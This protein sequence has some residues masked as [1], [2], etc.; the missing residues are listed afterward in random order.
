[1]V[2]TGTGDQR[3]HPQRVGISA[4]WA[5][6]RARSE[7]V[8]CRAERISRRYGRIARM[9]TSVAR[10]FPL[11]NVPRPG[12]CDCRVRPRDCRMVSPLTTTGGAALQDADVH[13]TAGL[14]CEGTRVRSSRHD[15]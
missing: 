9:A 8:P 15:T 2:N 13:R 1:V 11:A 7:W 3:Y 5:F 10:A 6:W 14:G 12:A 4:K